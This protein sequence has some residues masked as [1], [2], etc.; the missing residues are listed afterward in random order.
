MNVQPQNLTP[1][2]KRSPSILP[3][4]RIGLQLIEPSWNDV[5]WDPE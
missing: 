4:H 3:M 1:D 5:W 2:V